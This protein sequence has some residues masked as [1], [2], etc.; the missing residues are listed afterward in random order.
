MNLPITYLPGFVDNPTET[1]NA[2]WAELAWRRIGETPRREYYCNDFDK[3]YTYGRG[4]GVRTYE[5]QPYHPA[6]MATRHKLENLTNTSFEV[7]FLN[8]YEN[9]RDQ[10]G[11]HADDSPEMDPNRPIAIVSLGA[12]REIW[13]TEQGDVRDPGKRTALKL[14]HG[15]LCLMAPGMQRT[16]FHRIPK[17][18]FECGPRISE[19]FRGYVEPGR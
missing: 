9:S 17:A 18:G 4:A 5:R 12:E 15:S 2:L 3:A 8:G 10:L 14:Q 13:F 6:I 19:T 16:H 1:F 11:W 7:V